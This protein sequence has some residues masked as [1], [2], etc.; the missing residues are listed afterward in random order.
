MTGREDSS[1]PACRKPFPRRA[2]SK[3]FSKQAELAGEGREGE[4]RGRER[5]LL[6]SRSPQPIPPSLTRLTRP[7]ATKKNR[8]RTG[9]RLEGR[10]GAT[11]SR[12]EVSRFAHPHDRTQQLL[13]GGEV[14]HVLPPGEPGLLPLGGV[15]HPV[16]VLG[17]DV[18]VEREVEPAV[19][20]KH[21]LHVDL[22]TVPC[23]RA[24]GRKK[25]K[26]IKV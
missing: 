15:L 18:R 7:F 10:G 24:S 4:E 14:R 17:G 11:P 2:P 22:D 26:K 8:V 13:A 19:P 23:E 6:A 20:G 25:E 21:L 3:R 12:E 16:H 5:G 9:R 1:H